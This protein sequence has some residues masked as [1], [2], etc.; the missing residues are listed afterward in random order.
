MKNISWKNRWKN[1]EMD[2]D[3]RELKRNIK[4]RNHKM[5]RRICKS[6]LNKKDF[7]SSVDWI[8]LSDKDR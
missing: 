6:Y 1:L 3:E 7:D 4:K 2:Q 8:D 5:N